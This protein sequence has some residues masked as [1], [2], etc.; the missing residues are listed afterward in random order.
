M[1]NTVIALKKSSTPSATPASLAYGELAI[2]YADGKL[3]YKAANGSILEISGSGGGGGGGS[4]N[5]FSTINVNGTLVVSD[6]PTNILTLVPSGDITLTGDAVN[7]K[8]TIGM[9]S[10]TNVVPAFDQA[11]SAQTI[12]IAAFTTANAAVN[13]ATLDGANTAV[14]AG[15]NNY[16][17]SV[18]AGAN[19][20]VGAGA[21]S[22]SLATLA[23]ANTAVGAGANSYLL[24]VIAGANTAVGAGA[25][26]YATAVGTEANVIAIAAFTAA[27]A[28]GGAGV[29]AAFDQANTAQTIAIAAFT[30]ANT[31]GGGGSS[32]N[33]A[34]IIVFSNTR[35]STNANSG[36][37]IIAGGLG[38]S[39]NIY[40]ANR[41][42]YSNT[43]NVSVVYTY[44][45][46]ITSSLDTVFG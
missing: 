43:T 29:A 10:S 45:N 35:I 19:T 23:G 11:N 6:S 22:Y 4:S 2:N 1:A 40:T 18:I 36:A 41:I 24:S 25:N 37:V 20:T 15:A 8:I 28:A 27:N 38:V 5:S 32:L 13:V 3:F 14:G 33:T 42:G 9:S 34:N 30:Q 46:T 7:D 12:A 31:G 16:L 17:L 39:G 26:A 21:N 44:Y